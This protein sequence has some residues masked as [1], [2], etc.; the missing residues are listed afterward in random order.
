[1]GQ[2][3]TRIPSEPPPRTSAQFTGRMVSEQPE[4]ED[5]G[6]GFL[7]T[8]AYVVAALAALGGGAWLAIH[9]SSRKPATEQAIASPTVA[10]SPAAAASPVAPV[11]SAPAVALATTLAVQ[12]TGESASAPERS[13]A[14][15]TGVFDGNKTALLDAYNQALAGDASTNDGMLVRLRVL[16][17]GSVAK[18]SVVTSTAPNPGLD[19]EVVKDVSGWKFAAFSGTQVEVDYPVIFSRNPAEQAAVEADLKARVASLSP[20]ESPEY[21]ASPAA[22]PTP[23]V[24]EK[25]APV[26][27]AA[28]VSPR[29]HRRPPREVARPRPTPSL[30]DR[31]SDAL[32][33]SPKLR[34][35]KAYTNPGGSV[36]LVGKV[37]DDNDKMLAERTVRRVSG[38]TSVVDTLT[39]DTGM[40]AQQQAKIQ[41]QL[42]NAG[43]DKVTVKVIGKDAFLNG[44][45]KTELEKQR[46]ATI[47]QGAA[48][49]VVRENLIRVVPGNMFGF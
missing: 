11:A 25:P 13:V 22:P 36:T 44:E 19:A 3:G 40:W 17:D 7:T 2:A 30:Y 39:T 16:P 28:E 29:P 20:N 12:V 15:A 48:P 38:V 32:K 35:V 8:I 47:A 33:G 14:A 21:A 31:V 34:R 4:E 6:G 49:V 45:V 18:A 9:L 5:A 37:F 26:P 23:A 41:Q 10:V 46:A 24:V 43:L 1:M 42:A 27:P